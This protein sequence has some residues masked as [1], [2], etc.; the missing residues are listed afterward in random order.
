[1]T[2]PQNLGLVAEEPPHGGTVRIRGLH[3]DS[4][5]GDAVRPRDEIVAVDGEDV[6]TLGAMEVG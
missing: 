3:P 5:L 4:L 2:T 6:H 1:M